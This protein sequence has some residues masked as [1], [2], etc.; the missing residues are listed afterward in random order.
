GERMS[1]AIE[2]LRA[3]KQR[4]I[5][6]AKARGKSCGVRWAQEAAEYEELKR[7]DDAPP[8][9]PS[10]SNMDHGPAALILLMVCGPED[11]RSWKAVLDFWERHGSGDS[12]DRDSGEFWDG[13]FEG[14]QEVHNNVIRQL[15]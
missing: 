8:F 15:D 5:Q 11:D 7:F 13:F 12:L 9:Q 6:A 10:K 2:R 14:V 1:A 4:Y 3:S